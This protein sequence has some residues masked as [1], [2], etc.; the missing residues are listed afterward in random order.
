MLGALHG[1]KHKDGGS[2]YFSNQAPRTYAPKPRYAVNFWKRRGDVAP[3]VDVIKLI[4]VRAKRAYGIALPQVQSRVRLGDSRSVD[5]Q[6]LL[7]DIGPIT[8]VV[9]SPPYYGLRT[10]RPDQWLREWFLGGEEDV[11]YSAEGQVRHDSPEAFADD[12]RGVWRELAACAA[13]DAR[14]VIR[15]GSIN[16]RPVDPSALVRSSI[17]G[18]AWRVETVKNAG[19][20]STGRRQAPYFAGNLG[21]AIEEV[22]VWCRLE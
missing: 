3:L 6:F 22:D 16:D 5:W 7:R 4:Q 18:T 12:L 17:W 20:S 9:T 8:W 14:M 13:P 21:P 10:Y 15:F 11:S 2:S 19:L 1:P